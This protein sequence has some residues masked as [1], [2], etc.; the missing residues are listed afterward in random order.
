MIK[1]LT[2]DPFLLMGSSPNTSKANRERDSGESSMTGISTRNL[3]CLILLC[4][5][6]SLVLLTGFSRV[7]ERHVLAW[8]IAD[9]FEVGGLE[10]EDKELLIRT[11]AHGWEVLWL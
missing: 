4:L 2:G 9:S 6:V 3:G 11:R 8:R 5:L 10:E 7:V 1:M